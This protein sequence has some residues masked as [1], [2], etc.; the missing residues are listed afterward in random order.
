MKE[1]SEAERL[2]EWEA[3]DEMIL[4]RD[5]CPPMRCTAGKFP[6]GTHTIKLSRDFDLRL[7]LSVD[8]TPVGDGEEYK[9]VAHL[10]TL[11]PGTFVGYE[12]T[13]ISFPTS[14]CIVLMSPPMQMEH[15]SE[16]PMHVFR[17]RHHVASATQQWTQYGNFA[18][19]GRHGFV[20]LGE[21]EWTSDWF[22]NGTSEDIFP[23]TTERT[24]AT[25][26]QRRRDVSEIVIEDKGY[27]GDGMA[28]DRVV[29]R[30]ES[31]TFSICR[32]HSQHAP[33]ALRPIA[34]EFH[35]P[36]PDANTREAIAEIVSFAMGRRLM[37]VGSTTFD[38]RG[39]P[40]VAEV[41]APIGRGILQ[42]CAV[43]EHRPVYLERDEVLGA[44]GDVLSML[45]PAYLANRDE[46]ELSDALWSYWTAIETPD[47][48][49]LTL[50]SAAVETIKAAWFLSPR[51]T[52][53]GVNMEE[54]EFAELRARLICSVEKDLKERPR[55]DRVVNR[56]SNAFFMS[57][58]EKHEAFFEELGLKIGENEQAAIDARNGQ[59][60][61]GVKR[62]GDARKASEH[63]VAYRTLF[64]RVFLR[65][66]GYEGLYVDH[67]T[68]GWPGRSIGVAAGEEKV[69]ERKPEP[70][71]RRRGVPKLT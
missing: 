29:V 35:Q 68:L 14:S 48:V 16:G 24:H 31:L 63:A 7:V 30:T 22:V 62:S 66:L 2:L 27:A 3:S 61:R 26:F 40:V 44:F 37:R 53:K 39:A 60:H 70:R 9:D 71:A 56:L 42:L 49:N 57:T 6:S 65:I 15:V 52:S 47:G 1:R 33:A 46:F 4:F 67:T 38:A 23:L 12:E 43:Q 18:P 45:V 51:S 19:G 34:L 20:P 17:R 50:F 36:I 10:L 5:R 11:K 13:N 32:V 25:T 8:G 41:V 64:E 69:A 58:N 59:T 21:P 55:G 54:T 28:R